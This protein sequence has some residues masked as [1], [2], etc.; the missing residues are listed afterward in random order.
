MSGMDKF[1]AYF[2]GSDISMKA[3]LKA[4]ELIDPSKDELLLLM[5]IPMV[6]IQGV[7]GFDEGYKQKMKDHLDSQL[8][9]LKGRGVRCR[10]YFE[11][12]DIVDII[13][14]MAEYHEVTT[15]IL[16]YQKEEK[17]SP[18]TPGSISEQVSKRCHRPVL[19]I[20]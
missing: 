6:N 20:Q 10:G 9:I 5:V 1:L 16:G 13:I 19:A 3:L 14:N 12:G 4:E 8:G 11:E 2:D 7:E 18:F 15:V 17:M